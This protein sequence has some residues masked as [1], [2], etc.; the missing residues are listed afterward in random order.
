LAPDLAERLARTGL[1]ASLAAAAVAAIERGTAG[2]YGG[3][4]ALTA[5]EVAEL[6]ARLEPVRFGARS[7]LLW[8]L[9]WLGAV[10]AS[11]LPAQSV[12]ADPTLVEAIAAY[13]AKDYA[14]AEA[15]FA[16]VF[17]ATG[18]RRCWQAIGN[19]HYRRG[20]LPRALW[21]YECARL[22]LP[23]DAE[24]LA[25]L[26][27]VRQRLQLEVAQ[28]G[29]L[30]D[31]ASLRDRLLPAERMW[32]LAAT[33]GLSA[34]LLLLGWR[35]VGCRWLAG[36][37]AVPAL[38][39]ALDLGWWLPARAPMAIAGQELALVAEPRPDLPAVATVRAG[40]ELAVLGSSLGSFV[41]VRVGERTGYV[42]SAR[43]L[44]VQ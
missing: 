15:G 40:K 24:L 16:A 43:L 12:S 17:A 30:A 37:L 26:Q 44:L 39:L 3:A 35:R 33:M 20:D 7:L 34:A 21:A 2:R 36:I 18:D 27:L 13:R 9:L 23:R 19:C 31:L 10:G 1:D 38:L 5:A 4:A 32:L 25:N 14:S 11:P 42:E 8:L 41:R 29:M 28:P 6:V 22:G